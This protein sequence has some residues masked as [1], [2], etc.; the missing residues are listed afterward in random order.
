MGARV[1]S[2][3]VGEAIDLSADRQSRLY[4]AMPYYAGET[5]D[6]R[7]RRRPAMAIDDGVSVAARLARGIAALHRLHIIHRDIKPDNVILTEDGGLRLI[8][9]GVARL[10]RIEDFTDSEV[11][12]T[13]T[14]MAP[15][16]Y[17]GEHGSEASD[18][19]ALG[20]TLYYM[21]TGRYPYGEVEA[22]SRPRFEAP[23]PP[24][25]YRP[26]MPAWLDAALLRAVAVNPDDRFGDIVE[27]LRILED[28]GSRAVGAR[29]RPLSLYDRNPL[30]FLKVLCWGLLVLL[31]ASLATR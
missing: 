27:L 24:S 18:Q 30:L 8:D 15:E 22:F 29:H 1:H 4:V 3:F 31:I 25:R 9:L 19:F 16:L 5:L 14:Y 11:P 28:G 26:D 17:E 13:P 23:T 12:G 21:F 2:P 10:P 7:V 6:Q 20:V